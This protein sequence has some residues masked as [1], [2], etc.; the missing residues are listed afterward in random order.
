MQGCRGYHRIWPDRN[1]LT[2]K[3]EGE[4]YCSFFSCLNP[5]S[6]DRRKKKKQIAFL[7]PRSL[8]LE[9]HGET[10]HARGKCLGTRRKRKYLGTRRERNMST[11]CTLEVVYAKGTL[12]YKEEVDLYRYNVPTLQIRHIRW[13]RPYD[14]L[15]NVMTG[16]AIAGL[17]LYDLQRPKSRRQSLATASE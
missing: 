4:T 1:H 8:V 15:G 3:R 5:R 6:S 14:M 2:K 11:E 17:V 9:P 16:G 13:Q 12:K 10:S 7:F